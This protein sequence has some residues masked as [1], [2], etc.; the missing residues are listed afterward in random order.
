MAVRVAVEDGLD[1]VKRALIENGFEVAKLT[2]GSMGNVDV[3]VIT[4]ISN[5]FLGVEDTRGNKFPVIEAAG[6]TAGEVVRQVKSRTV[7]SF[8]GR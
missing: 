3:A 2:T 8:R 7:H 4:G 5:N 6:M 1:H